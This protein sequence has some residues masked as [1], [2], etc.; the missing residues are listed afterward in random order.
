MQWIKAIFWVAVLG[1]IGI[2]IIENLNFFDQ[3]ANLKFLTYNFSLKLYL[4]L[5][6][7]FFFGMLFGLAYTFKAWFKKRNE[8]KKK[9]EEIRKLKEELDSLRNLPLTEEKPQGI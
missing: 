7:S 3:M 5:F 1:V 8:L 9:N 2:F 4:L 6:F